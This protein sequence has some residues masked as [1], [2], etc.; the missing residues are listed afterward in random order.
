MTPH[1]YEKSEADFAATVN[2]AVVRHVENSSRNYMS[3]PASNGGTPPNFAPCKPQIH[4]RGLQ[5]L[6][7]ATIVLNTS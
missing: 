4:T 1:I 3:D 2:N 7:S 6:P 5:E